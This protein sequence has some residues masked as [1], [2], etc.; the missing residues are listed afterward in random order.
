MRRHAE[1]RQEPATRIDIAGI[2]A[3]R[4]PTLHRRLSPLGLRVLRLI[5]HERRLNAVTQRTGHLDAASFVDTILRRLDI[6]VRV[7]GVEHLARARRPVVCS[8]HP[9]GA[10]EGLALM[11]ALWR[12]A[13]GCLVPANDLLCL[14]APL[15]PIIV[16]VRHGAL[17]RASAEGFSAAFGGESPILVFPAGV[18]A[19][20][21]GGRLRES[22]WRASFVTRAR[23]TGRDLL[24]V[25]VSGRNSRVFYAIHKIRRVLG[26][27]LN[28]EMA[29]LVHEMF[30]R[31]GDTVIARFLAPHRSGGDEGPDRHA[32]QLLASEIQARV[33]RE[34]A[35]LRP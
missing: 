13:G 3:E 29:M 10:I 35:G 8:N 4:S 31:R 24:P 26:V 30:R 32:D 28:V 23:A 1:R 22:P 16:P 33:E 15:A 20:E 21:Y 11:S 2:L 25:A 27:R 5:A 34:A 7:E 17:S 14:L 6:T 12:H 18:T 19:R 9:S